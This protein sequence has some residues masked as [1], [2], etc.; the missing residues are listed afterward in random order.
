MW[1]SEVHK[2]LSPPH[3][4]SV[5]QEDLTGPHDVVDKTPYSS[6]YLDRKTWEEREPVN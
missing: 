2:G 6:S 5:Q 4:G 1:I 3:I